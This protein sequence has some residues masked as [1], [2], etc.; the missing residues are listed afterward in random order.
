ME[1]Q[2]LTGYPSIDRPWLKYYSK[3]APEYVNEEC[4][5]SAFQYMESLNTERLEYIALQYFGIKISYKKLFGR[6]E[7][8]ARALKASGILE[9]DFVSLCMP[10]IPEMIYF[11]YGLNR[12]G[13]VACLIDPRTNAEGILQR[14]NET[15]SKMLIV[16]TDIIPQKI[17]IIADRLNTMSIIGVSPIDS[18]ACKSVS[19]IAVKIAYL[20]KG[21]K[22]LPRYV[23]Y[24]HFIG[25]AD[26]YVEDINASFQKDRTA[27]IVYT[28]GT[29]GTA[30][31][32]MITN[33]C[34]I[35]SR[36]M[37]QYGSSNIDGNAAFLG[38]IPFF[39]AY[40]AMT[41]MNNSLCCG[42]NIILI[43]QY[44]PSDFGKLMLKYRPASAL[45]VPRFWSEFARNFTDTNLSYLKNAIC[46]GDK[47]SPISVE[48]I[49]EYLIRNGSNRL[50]IGYGSSEF[51]GGIVITTENGP[52]E[53]NSTGE[54]LPGVI[55]MV[56]DPDTREE[57][58]YG[59]DGELCFH[60]PTMM[61]GYFGN[62][63]ETRQITIFKNGL[64]FYC[65]GDKGHITEDGTVHIVDRY[66]RV[67]MRPDGHTVHAAPI[68]NAILQH[69]A[70][71]VCAVA[72]VS[73]DSDAGVIPTA[74][75]V[76]KQNIQNKKVVIDEID[77][78]CLRQIPERDKAHIYVILNKLP[79]TPMGKVDY[80]YL[81]NIDLKT[82]YFVIKDFS[83]INFD[84]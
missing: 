52:Y 1:T 83:F 49:N 47:I 78:M 36:K 68:E 76:V 48:Q 24:K 14:V 57:L 55:G 20:F 60:S 19:A 23:T 84:R 26:S 38:V 28:S 32:V 27:I 39:S 22:S 45:G 50:K 75:I 37:I 31:G 65:T 6:I 54:L 46:G 8:I 56:I 13:A 9:D 66:K 42:W 44:K 30:K 59:F 81:E 63:K 10:N 34:M 72:G 51:G 35:A 33:E 71:E 29:T 70:V 62:E 80:R 40:G 79:Y 12:I 77:L 82:V 2:K 58:K 53:K 11:V 21:H 64:K 15:G 41:G 18:L 61:K 73:F 7:L 5:Q 25:L 17:S 67:M 3:D 74:F 43:P 4:E 16:V 69:E